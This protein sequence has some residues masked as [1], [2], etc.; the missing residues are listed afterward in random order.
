MHL[1]TILVDD[2]RQFHR[3]FDVKTDVFLLVLRDAANVFLVEPLAELSYEQMRIV[4]TQIVK[5]NRNKV[6]YAILEIAAVVR[7]SSIQASVMAVISDLS[8]VLRIVKGLKAYVALS[9][10]I[11]LSLQ[12]IRQLCHRLLGIRCV[13]SLHF[14]LNMPYEFLYTI[15]TTIKL[16]RILNFPIR[17]LAMNTP[18]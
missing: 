6:G 15:F 12:Y 1:L 10:L 14:A 17:K 9:R 7:C 16:K 8:V 3:D 5:H 11:V 18:S 2:S 4:A 13:Q